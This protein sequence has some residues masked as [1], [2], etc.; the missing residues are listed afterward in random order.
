MTGWTIAD[1]PPQHGRLAVVT[2]ATGGLGFETAIALAAAG[3][4]VV[5][6]SRNDSKGAE[7]LEK[8]RAAHPAAQVRFEQLDLASLRSVAACADRLLAAD[9]GIDLLVNN[10]AVMALPRR[11]E[12]G[13]GFEQQFGT[14]YL[15]HFALTARLLPA[16]RRGTRTRVVNVSSLAAWQGRIDLDDLQSERG[17]RPMRVYGNT[18]LAMLLFTLELQRRSDAG[19]WGLLSAAAHPGWARTDIIANV[20]AETGLEQGFVRL[21][22]LAARVLAQSAAAGAQ[23]T[24]FAATSPTACGGGYYGPSGLFFSGPPVAT[25]LPPRAKNAAVAAGLWEASERLTGVA[26]AGQEVPLA[27]T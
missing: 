6:A 8:I 27:A 13:D 5:L 11:R 14:N 26:F 17:Y 10:A 24:L 2:G 15:G 4:E 1:M 16:L 18:K 21:A 22:E 20:P 12:T 9:R 7:A 23:H 19:G 3:A 25:R